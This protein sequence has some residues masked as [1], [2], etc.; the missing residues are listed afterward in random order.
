MHA[1]TNTHVYYIIAYNILLQHHVF[2]T[3]GLYLPVSKYCNSPTAVS[4]TFHQGG[5]LLPNSQLKYIEL[6]G[7]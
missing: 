7:K 5:Y 2:C 4:F 6:G 3:Y 1:H